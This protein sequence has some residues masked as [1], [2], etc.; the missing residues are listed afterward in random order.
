MPPV[1][2]RRRRRI[3]SVV[4]GGT[5]VGGLP[6]PPPPPRPVVQSG[7]VPTAERATANK[8]KRPGVGGLPPPLDRFNSQE[9][10]GP[11]R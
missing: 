11:R 7:Q 1:S 8:V 2:L 6:P 10:S 5:G 4:G 9:R 3:W